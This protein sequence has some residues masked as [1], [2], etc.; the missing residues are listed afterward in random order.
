VTEPEAAESSQQHQ[1]TSPTSQAL[2]ASLTASRARYTCLCRD[3]FY[4]PNETIQGFSSDR[5]ESDAGNFSCFPCPGGCFMCD[6]DGS[7]TSGHEEPEDFLTES[8]LRAFFGAILGTCVICCFVLAFIVFRQRKCKV[9]RV[10]SLSVNCIN[11]ISISLSL[12][13]SLT[14]AAIV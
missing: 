11:L 1:P 7:C 5:V 8:F 9:S 2:L 3:G 14:I 4:V 12:S 13:L 6:K 10:C